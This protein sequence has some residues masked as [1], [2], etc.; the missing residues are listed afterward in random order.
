MP[1]KASISPPNRNVRQRLDEIF[2]DLAEHAAVTGERTGIVGS[3]S[4]R[5]VIAS[6]AKQSIPVCLSRSGDG[7]LRRYA[8]RNDGSPAN[9]PHQPHLQFGLFHDHTDIDA[10]GLHDAPIGDTPQPVL[11]LL[12]LRESVVA[13]QRV[14]AG[15]DEIERAI[16]CSACQRGV[17]RS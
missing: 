4:S 3:A 10:I 15:R 8:P 13:L 1:C 2:L 11:C 12:D 7:L 6:G 14:A 17:G 9:L 5:A 16:E